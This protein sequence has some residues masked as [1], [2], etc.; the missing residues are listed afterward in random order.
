MEDALSLRKQN[1]TNPPHQPKKLTVTD[2]SNLV[3][4][5]GGMR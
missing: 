3:K 5:P 1:K 4:T 2:C